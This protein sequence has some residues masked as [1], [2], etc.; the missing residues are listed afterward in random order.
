MIPVGG[1]Q[2]QII[3]ISMNFSNMENKVCIQV[4]LF[5]LFHVNFNF[6]LK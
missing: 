3:K 2:L 6:M 1:I 5:S 4:L